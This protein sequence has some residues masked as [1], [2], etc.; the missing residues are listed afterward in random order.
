[1]AADL[2]AGARTTREDRA[3]RP[4]TTNAASTAADGVSSACRLDRL[5]SGRRRQ[6]PYAHRDGRRCGRGV[7][8]L[9]TFG[10][11]RS[12]TLAE[13]AEATTGRVAREPGAKHPR[14]QPRVANAAEAEQDGV[15][16]G[17][18]AH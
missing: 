6:G 14:R 2:L 12:A 8:G 9:A 17:R 10:P 7:R 1:M 13:R 5:R 4:A 3:A 11:E 18:A 16:R 15:A